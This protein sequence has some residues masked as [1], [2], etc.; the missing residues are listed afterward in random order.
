MRHRKTGNPVTD[1]L[2]ALLLTLL[3]GFF[4]RLAELMER[5]KSGQYQPTPATPR[6]AQATRRPRQQTPHP[7]HRWPTETQPEPAE[8]PDAAPHGQKAPS[9]RWCGLGK[10]AARSPA[11]QYAPRP[12]FARAAPIHPPPQK[13]R[14][15]HVLWRVHFVTI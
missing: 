4:A 3:T 9:P 10:G 12:T 2:V 1:L 13:S 8:I 15:K 14:R 7:S 11:R 6:Q 5:I